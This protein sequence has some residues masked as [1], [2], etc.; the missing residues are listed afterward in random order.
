MTVFLNRPVTEL[1]IRAREALGMTQEKFGVAL[2]ASHRTAS[3]WEAGQSAPVPAEVCKLAA[4]VYPKDA[5]LAAEL[6]IAANETLESL[7]IVTPPA[8]PPSSA[9]LPAPLPTE[10]LVDSVVC[11]AA[12]ALEAAPITLRGALYAAFRRAR[13]LRLSVDDVEKALAPAPSKAEKNAEAQAPRQ[14]SRRRV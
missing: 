7:G 12:D 9:P 6:A 10:L 14:S 2:Q 3:R 1:L 5:K 11:A 4:M 13:E 8:A